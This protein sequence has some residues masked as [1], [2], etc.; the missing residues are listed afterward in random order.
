MLRS[1]LALPFLLLALALPA[2]SSTPDAT[3]PPPDGPVDITTD[4]GPV[5]GSLGDGARA[6][7]GIPYAAPPVGPLRFLPPTEAPA[8][9]TPRDGAQFGPKCPQL[10]VDGKSLAPETSEDCLYLNVWTPRADVK[11]APVFVWI[12]GGGFTI[13][14]GSN[15]LYNGESLARETGAII[16]TINYRL[17]PLGF[18]SHTAF[19][20]EEGVATSPSPGLL[21]QQAALKW[22]QRNI[23]A[24]GGDPQDVT[25]A[26][27]SAGGIS[28]C[29]Q[30][31]MPGSKGLFQRA[32]IESGPCWGAFPSKATAEDQGDRLAAAVGCTDPGTVAA[33]LRGRSVEEILGALPGKAAYFDAKGDSY[34]PVVD[35][36]VLPKVPMDALAAGEGAGVPTILGTNVNEGQLFVFLYQTSFGAPPTAADV[37]ASLGSI[38]GASV[39]DQIAAQYPVDTDPP[40]AFTDIITDGAFACPTRRAARALAA[41]GVPAFLYQFTW[42]FKV[43]AISG[44]VTSHSFEVPFV[45]RNAYV[46]TKLDDADVVVSDA[47]DGYWFR[48]ARTGDPN[49]DGAVA[50][51]AYTA[52]NDEDLVI[53][54]PVSTATGLKK[55]RCDFWDTIEK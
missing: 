3:S 2:C 7:L 5:H 42:P 52:A 10:G 24:F 9:T 12:H 17:G 26:G 41:G 44:P 54:T 55:A 31:A 15:P 23:A 35:G 32:V 27:E 45:F 4:K 11:D 8:W 1:S 37:R 33:C 14:S 51:P 25:V 21:D 28:V 39:V 30:L 50:W 40:Q 46:G 6:F 48:F 38:F 34:G 13:G 53:D 18:L 22:V 43:G 49:G 19:A 16:V 36:T 29:A 47:M 20:A